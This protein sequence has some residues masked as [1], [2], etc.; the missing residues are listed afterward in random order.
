MN[1]AS[2]AN[3]DDDRNGQR[4]FARW[5]RRQ[6][7][8]RERLARHRMLAPVAHRFLP[9]ELW[10]LT[11]RSV[12][13][14][15]ALGFVVAILVI[16]P[17]FQILVAVLLAP[18]VRANVP[19]AVVATFLNTPP[20]TI[21]L[22]LLARRVG[23]LMLGG[24][25]PHGT[26]PPGDGAHVQGWIE[27]LVRDAGPSTVVGLVAIAAIAGASGYLITSVIWRARTARLWQSR[28]D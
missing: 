11:R 8:T 20:T 26:L 14:G 18:L 19:T 12:P 15:V 3:M 4:R 10:R 13:R 5:A 23:D 25:A 17:G 27:W 7:P 24:R 1:R 28:H 9:N 22:L 16:V 2:S 21:P 6:V